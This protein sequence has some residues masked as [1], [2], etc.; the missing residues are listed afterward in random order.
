MT[1]PDFVP[2][3]ARALAPTPAGAATLRLLTDRLPG[4][5]TD[6]AYHP[7]EGLAIGDWLA[8]GAALQ[9][10]EAA[11]QW[12]LGDW[13][14]FGVRTYGSMASQGSKDHVKDLTGHTYD[15]VRKAARVAAKWSPEERDL[16]VPFDYY[17][18]V[19]SV[20]KPAA[21]ALIGAAVDQGWK[22]DQLRI[23]ADETRKVI[24]ANENKLRAALRPQPIDLVVHHADARALPIAD[25]TVDL[26]ITS[27]PYA[28]DKE[29][30]DGDIVVD[31]WP[32]FMVAWLTDAHRVLS[33]H[34]RLALNVPIDT[35]RPFPRPTY[36]QAL[37]AA[38]RAGFVYRSTIIWRDD[39][40]GKSVARGSVDSYTSPSI[41]FP[42]EA[43]IL[44]SKHDWSRPPL[45]DQPSDIDHLDWL[46]WTNGD[47]SFPGESQPW[48][49][50]VAP[51][52]EEL[53][54]R[55][56]HLLS[57][58]GDLVCDPFVG[59]GTTLLVCRDTGRRGVG[60]DIALEHVE[61]TRRRLV[62]D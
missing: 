35:T 9:H 13:W 47:W 19:Q 49:G 7:P 60:V 41:I 37:F 6:S 30:P 22:R 59:S 12:Y 57:A 28:L 56:I 44:F 45:R 5:F 62:L 48:E 33:D 17:A 43:I 32:A 1:V 36:G 42:G 31:D 46:K 4:V 8:V 40:L 14:R 15:V 29:Y 55:L 3:E 26:I 52:P 39:Q 11:V 58:P 2:T 20:P 21:V 16:A 27:P 51:F 24:R 18:S 25:G 34:G 38:Q 53:P 61:A 50:H 23:Q 10:V 54:R